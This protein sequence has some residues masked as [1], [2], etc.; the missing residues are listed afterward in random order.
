MKKLLKLSFVVVAAALTLF[1]ACKQDSLSPTNAN[2][3]G[4]IKNLDLKG[5]S[6]KDGA[7]HFDAWNSLQEG[8]DVL[9]KMP[10][11]QYKTFC[12]QLG[13]KSLE[14]VEQEELERLEKMRTEAEFSLFKEQ[15]KDIF[16][17]ENKE[18]TLKVYSKIM[19]RLLSREGIVRVKDDIYFYDDQGI[20]IANNNDIAALATA[21]TT[22][23]SGNNATV[24]NKEQVLNTR[25]ACG[26]A[27]NT[28]W[29]SGQNWRRGILA[30][31]TEITLSS[32]YDNTAIA[33]S[34]NMFFRTFSEGRSQ[35]YN[36][37]F[38]Y[39][40]DISSN[41]TMSVN[42]QASAR[43]DANRSNFI[44]SNHQLTFSSNNVT[45]ILYSEPILQLSPVV[46]TYQ[47]E[48]QKRY[49]QDFK[50]DFTFI[51]NTYSNSVGINTN[52]NCN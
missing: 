11:D 7:L 4:E 16:L 38:G 19:P 13:F 12:E 18:M 29:I 9:N 52:I 31:G 10:Y 14:I 1:T 2:E 17:F 27:P 42:M 22:R 5:V 45:R 49:N 51:N 41:H 37:W 6:M 43:T 23:K 44:I 30:C 33:A 35:K 25:T 40:T 46:M 26:I 8:I 20:I 24:F 50:R 15:N 21:K 28:G 32:A 36:T 48:Y 34:Y 39:W 47:Y 3:V